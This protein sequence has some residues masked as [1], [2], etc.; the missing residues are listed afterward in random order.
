MR[1]DVSTQ[2]SA[3]RPRRR[4]RSPEATRAALLAAG[5]QILAADPAEHAFDH[6]KAA[7]VATAAGRTQGAFFHHWATQDDYVFDLIDYAFAPEHST[8]LPV[9]E[10]SLVADLTAGLS[11]ADA[12]TKATAAA[13]AA[14]PGDP[15]TV[16]EFLI[17]KRAVSDAA[18]GTW[19]LER[20]QSLDR[21]HAPMFARLLALVGRRPR[22]PYTAE[23]V[24]MAIPAL[25]QTVSMR[26]LVDGS[27]R[28]T[29]LTASIVLAVLPLL[30]AAADDDRDASAYL[31][32]LGRATGSASAG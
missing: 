4:P 18:F 20:Y 13:L 24:A 28:P 15:Q 1:R 21:V 30:T 23:T 26:E 22:P 10:Q 5:L 16:I 27:V 6:L 9:V 25:V 7:R 3:P 8:T 32:W 14:M 29:G 12:V 31:D 17:W 11:L 2:F 19:L